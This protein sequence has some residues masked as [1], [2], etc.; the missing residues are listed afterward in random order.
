MFPTLQIGRAAF[1]VPGLVLIIGIWL[2]LLLAE[3]YCE[4]RRISTQHLNNLIFLGITSGL[5]GARLGYVLRYMELFLK[6][7]A[8][9]LSLRPVF[10]DPVIGTLVAI[11]AMWIYIQRKNLPFLNMLDVLTPFFAVIVIASG[12]SDLSSGASFGMPTDLPWSI[13]LW[14]Q[15]RHPT[16]IY[17]ITISFLILLSIWPTRGPLWSDRPGIPFLRFVA[18]TATCVLF[19]EAFRGDSKL[20]FYGIRVNQ[21]IA[22]IVLAA[23]LYGLGILQTQKSKEIKELSND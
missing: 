8:A 19:L 11:I 7:P 15:S 1:P 17:E 12:I 20:I 2:G 13:Y 16:Q 9:I 18:L 3:R 21:V 5:I 14:G 23:S 6:N 10:L 22:W 4:N